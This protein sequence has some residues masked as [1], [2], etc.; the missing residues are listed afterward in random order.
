MNISSVDVN[1]KKKPINEGRVV[2]YRRSRSSGTG[3]TRSCAGRPI[4]GDPTTR[5]VPFTVAQCSFRFRYTWHYGSDATRRCP[6][7]PDVRRCPSRTTGTRPTT[8]G[9]ALGRVR[10]RK[11]S[12]LRRCTCADNRFSPAQTSTYWDEN[13]RRFL[14][15]TRFGRVQWKIE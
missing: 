11:P 8:N 3:H 1:K 14:R 13:G 6:K 2:Y 7:A 12:S 4:N 10:S 9:F 15:R 5:V